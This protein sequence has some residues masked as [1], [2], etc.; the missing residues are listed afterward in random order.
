L[1]GFPADA[2]ALLV[3]G[4][5]MANFVGLAAARASRASVDVRAEQRFTVY[6]STETHLSVH[7]AVGLLGIGRSNLRSIPVTEDYE[8]D[9]VLLERAII[10]DRAAGMHPLVIVGNAGTV[11]T[12]AIDPI[13]ELARIAKEQGMWLHVDGAFGA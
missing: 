8:I 13:G 9:P 11:N 4:G 10:D 7:K 12:G 5:S 6:A 1:F 2:S 3:T